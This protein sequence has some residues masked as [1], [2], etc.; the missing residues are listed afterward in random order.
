MESRHDQIIRRLREYPTRLRDEGI[1]AYADI[2]A[3]DVIEQCASAA[4]SGRRAPLTDLQRRKIIQWSK[5]QPINDYLYKDFGQLGLP[6][7]AEWIRLN[8][9]GTHADY[10]RVQNDLRV[11]AYENCMINDYTDA[12]EQ[13]YCQRVACAGPMITTQREYDEYVDSYDNNRTDALRYCRSNYPEYT[14]CLEY[15]GPGGFDPD[16]FLIIDNAGGGNCFFL[17]IMI[18][19]DVERI[20]S[21]GGDPVMPRRR[22]N[23]EESMEYR[24]AAVEWLIRNRSNVAIPAHGRGTVE[25]MIRG[26]SGKTF[27]K[28][29]LDMKRPTTDAGPPEIIA[30]SRVL[31]R[32]VIVLTLDKGTYV[33]LVISYIPETNPIY[34]RHLGSYKGGHYQSLIPRVSIPEGVN[35]TIAAPKPFA[36]R[37][38]PSAAVAAAAKPVAAPRPAPRPVAVPKPVAAPRPVA[39][40]KPAPSAGNH[41]KTT[42]LIEIFPALNS[43]SIEILNAIFRDKLNI[44]KCAS[45]IQTSSGTTT[46]VTGYSAQE[47]SKL[48]KELG[49]PHTSTKAESCASIFSLISAMT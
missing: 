35:F 6:E 19:M 26:D 38:K 11:D 34:I 9:G 49:L 44:T 30:I 48:A 18:F 42:D 10:L 33:P 15:N 14:K 32:T 5:T 13:Y 22:F 25:Q 40:P 12:D 2:T 24:N 47:L 20:I 3:D 29:I 36:P 16:E 21:T 1:Y 46:H 27:D 17:S 41:P 7:F 37:P 45:R 31:G 28:Y 23:C 8:P 43:K 39:A 4:A